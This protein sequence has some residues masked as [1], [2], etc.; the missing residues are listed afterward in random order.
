MFTYIGVQCARKDIQEMAVGM[1]TGDEAGGLMNIG[2]RRHHGKDRSHWESHLREWEP[3][4]H[5]T[6]LEKLHS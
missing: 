3:D 4:A 2:D 1:E 5:V 6:G